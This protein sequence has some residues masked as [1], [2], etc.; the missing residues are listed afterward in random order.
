MPKGKMRGVDEVIAKLRAAEVLIS[1][2]QSQE[3]AAKA[4]GVS[5][6][7]LI[8]WRRSTVACGWTREW[9]LVLAR[10]YLRTSSC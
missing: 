6:Q 4:M 9:H 3:L 7:T 8:R 5:A 2:G 10:A 1:Q